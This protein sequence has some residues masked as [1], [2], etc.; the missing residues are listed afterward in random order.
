MLTVSFYNQAPVEM[1]PVELKN[2]REWST[3]NAWHVMFPCAPSGNFQREIK[4]YLYEKTDGDYYLGIYKQLFP[5]K[6]EDVVLKEITEADDY[7]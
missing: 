2:K 7:V 5:I 6:R 1:T 4:L 3:G